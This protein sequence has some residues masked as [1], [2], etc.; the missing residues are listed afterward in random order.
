MSYNFN[1]TGVWTGF[2]ST[3][4]SC[5]WIRRIIIALTYLVSHHEEII[6]SSYYYYTL[7]H[8]QSDCKFG[9]VT[10]FGCCVKIQH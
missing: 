5:I 7:Q 1:Q 6:G 10:C 2:F 9:L 3:D 4:G 8:F